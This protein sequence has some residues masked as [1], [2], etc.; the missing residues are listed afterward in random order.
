M[1][2]LA[3]VAPH[4]KAVAVGGR[5]PMAFGWEEAGHVTSS[6]T[7]ASHCTAHAHHTPHEVAPIFPIYLWGN[8]GWENEVNHLRP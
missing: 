1:V 5:S 7:C 6:R 2:H 8:G 4:V 3:S